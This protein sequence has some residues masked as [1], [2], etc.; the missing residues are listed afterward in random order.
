MP[1][2][3]E[4]VMELQKMERVEFMMGGKHYVAVIPPNMTSPKILD[5]YK[6]PTGKPPAMDKKTGKAKNPEKLKEWKQKMGASNRELA[7]AA[8][9][10][11]YEVGK[12]GKWVKVEEP[13][14]KLWAKAGGAVRRKA[15]AIEKTIQAT[16]VLKETMPKSGPSPFKKSEKKITEEHAKVLASMGVVVPKKL[17]AAK[18][19]KKTTKA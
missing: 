2:V 5:M 9:I 7:Q 3:K 8:G 11:I 15:D 19:K 13:S 1:K 12:K 4:K 6:P 16:K 14:K 10:K 18:K 17:I